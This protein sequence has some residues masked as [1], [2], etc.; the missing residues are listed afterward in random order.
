M[1]DE[2]PRQVAGGQALGTVLGM[3]D[4]IHRKN[5]ALLSKCEFRF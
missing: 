3:A 2:R 5:N 4:I 1:H